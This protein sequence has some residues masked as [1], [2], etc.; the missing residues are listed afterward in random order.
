MIND[1]RL[2][3]CFPFDAYRKYQEEVIR[4]SI[5]AF[6]S[7]KRHVVVNAPVGFG[8][9]AHA[10]T[11][12]RYYGEGYIGTTQKSLQK[13]Y[14]GDFDLPE[15]Y[16]KTNYVCVK[17]TSQ[18]CDN[19]SCKGHF[20]E[21]CICPYQEAKTKCFNSSISIM[22]Y[23]LLFSLAQF[24]GGI[25]HRDI[26]IYDECHNL[27]NVLTDFVGLNIS[28]RSFKMFH[29]PLIPFPKEGSTS[30]E[31]VKWL[32]TR[33]IP[34]A[35]NQL[36]IV[37]TALNGY[38]DD[39][40][41]K[42][43]ARQYS[44]L[45][46]FIRKIH[47][48]IE[49]IGN[50]GR[51]CT[52]VEDTTISM[53]PLMVDFMAKE[54]L[55]SISDRVL[56]ISATV[57]SKELYCKCLGLEPDEVEYI[58]VGS[59]FPPE[60]RPVMFAPVGSMSYKNKKETLPKMAKVTDRLLD[61]HSNQRGI[62]HTGTYEIANYLY[63]NCDCRDRLVFPQSGERE[64]VIRAFFE[65][66]RDDL[67]LLSPSLMEGIDLKGDLAEFALICK[68]PF[69]SLGDTWTKEK[70]DYIVGWY[71]EATINKLVQSSG[72]HVRSETEKG[73]TYIMDETFK[74]FYNQNKFRFPKWWKESLHMR[75]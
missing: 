74:W 6:D 52:Q 35:T 55:E 1:E 63:D 10:I 71:A 48:I 24:G 50:G 30:I 23:S 4:Q 28:E 15:F 7:G 40:A 19:P 65:S 49:F 69:A 12:C 34:H 58:Q 20:K 26:A 14:C 32:D 3:Q 44:F 38:C 46:N 45:S 39:K 9:S 67:V 17:D 36:S 27:E 33:M 25:P 37:E 41:K 61:H 47:F 56:H 22:N 11:L 53:K 59:V 8:K 31:V 68:V 54:L 51:V 62:I 42:D 75:R 2:F 18:K 57:Q 72:R 60:N 16:G 5:E 66:K 73:I 70:M 64:E 29:I 21:D 43:Y 13:Q